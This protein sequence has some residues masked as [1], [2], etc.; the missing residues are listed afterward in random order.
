MVRTKS[1][2]RLKRQL[3]IPAAAQL[4]RLVPLIIFLFI[5]TASGLF[6]GVHAA[7][8]S[9]YP[10]LP[11]PV[12]CPEDADTQGNAAVC[13]GEKHDSG[14]KKDLSSGPSS[15]IT[16]SP[17]KKSAALKFGGSREP[18]AAEYSSSGSDPDSSASENPSSFTPSSEHLRIWQQL[19]TDAADTPESLRRYVITEERVIRPDNPLS[20]R[21]PDFR[22]FHL[23]SVNPVVKS[24]ENGR[25]IKN[26]YYDRDL[27]ELH[28]IIPAELSQ[29]GRAENYAC[30]GLSDAPLSSAGMVW[31]DRCSWVLGDGD[32]LTV[33]MDETSVMS[34]TSFSGF[35]FSQGHPIYLEARPLPDHPVIIHHQF[36]PPQGN[37]P[38]S[39]H[40]DHLKQNGFH[41]L[42]KTMRYRYPGYELT[43]YQLL[44]KGT[45]IP[46]GSF[47]SINFSGQ[48]KVLSFP[49]AF[50]A[51]L[52]YRPVRYNLQLFTEEGSLHTSRFH[53]EKLFTVSEDKNE[54]TIKQPPADEFCI[55]DYDWFLTPLFH[56]QSIV[57]QNALMPAHPVTLFGKR[58][59]SIPE[60]PDIIPPL[61][62]PE[63]EDQPSEPET[64]EPEEPVS[65]PSD[66]KPS[67][68]PGSRPEIQPE[69]EG[70][71][72]KLP[73]IDPIPEEADP[74]DTPAEPDPEKTDHSVPS[75]T[76]ESDNTSIS[77]TEGDPVP[78]PSA[79]KIQDCTEP[80]DSAPETADHQPLLL[81]L[82]SLLGSMGAL[83]AFLGRRRKS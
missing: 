75:H 43:G 46:A 33:G 14:Q 40:T 41:A 29:S 8:Q 42:L 31:D 68:E 61:P 70:Q 63:P 72:E 73:S 71:P 25:I 80:D 11:H 30:S 28:F 55:R 22:G 62:D 10:Q 83:M 44:K 47:Q 64:P 81:W 76:E 35:S 38:R 24:T 16:E 17:E 21:I 36:L 13:A 59:I 6:S 15:V 54:S 74:K 49:S 26:I 67:E 82:L 34:M 56:P 78:K 7:E 23:R 45:S 5:F 39:V 57:D 20:G 66:P 4:W 32:P 18:A 52:I 50:D 1:Q 27:V 58:K 12:N 3:S 60:D 79:E 51:A 77:E 37:T 2:I 48:Y 53:Q 9:T 19:I 69:P 65:P